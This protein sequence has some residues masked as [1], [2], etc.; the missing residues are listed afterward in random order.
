MRRLSIVAW[1]AATLLAA[2]GGGSQTI[3]GTA[4]PPPT[5]G[6]S[7]VTTV[8]VVSS[9]A[10]IAADGSNSATISATAKDANNNFVKGA[11][12]TFSAS[13]G[14]LAVTQA[15]TD[16]NGL[17]T[18]TLTAG[19]AAAGTS[20]TVTAASGTVSGKVSVMVANTQQTISVI[21]SLPQIPSDSSKAATI[22][23][24]VRNA[25]NQF[26]S[27]VPV[28]FT[29]TS[30][31]LTVTQAA[32]GVNGAA[33][34]TLN[35][36]GDPTDRT[37]TVTVT[38]G[39]STATVPVAVI[40]TK[41]TLTGSPN[42]V[43]GSQGT[44]TVALV[45]AGGNGIPNESVGLASA[46]GN[47]LSATTVTT[48]STGQKTFTMTAVNGGTD[49]ITATT[50]GLQATQS[51][52]VSSQ[53]FAFTAPA[54]NAQVN[55]GV[56]TTLTVAWTANGVAQSGQTVNFSATR[57]TLSASSA[58]TDAMGNASVTLT[59][60]TAGPSVISAS[61]NGVTAQ[62]TLNFVATLPT[63]VAVQA[64]P[65]TIATQ[66]QSTVTATVRDANNNLVQ[67]QVVDFAITKDSTGGSLSVA[68]ATTNAQGQAST[69]YT[70]STTTSASNGIIISATVQGTSVPP[71]STSLT[72]GGQTVFLSLGTGNLINPFS[73]TQYGL[74]Y[75]VQAVDAAGNGVNNVTVTFTV[76]SLGYIKGSRFWSGSTWATQANT[77]GT[78]PYAYVL[79]GI[80]GCRTE[81]LAGNGVLEP[82]E[83]YNGNGK[84]DPGLVVSTDVGSAITANGGS[85][86]V[87]L[88]YPR[89]HAYYVAVKLTATATVT[90]TQSSSSAVFW[91]Q[92]LAADF[93]SQNIAPPG[94]TSPYGTATTCANPN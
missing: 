15:T 55:L 47:T 13:A 2:C 85:A 62:M 92:G 26:V 67:G 36:A 68:S 9:A 93:N 22:T 57:G 31:G 45:D 25:Q 50:L 46:K 48:D 84:L 76:T 74:P 30:G 19:T 66:G 79:A 86:A 39:T 1:M 43:Q 56:V 51:V 89:D 82:G 12:V 70:A 88:I 24:L 83:D 34:A 3:T 71:G 37:I 78:D 59:S 21:T 42:L 52:V 33:T 65:S 16:A 73:T 23:A 64:S 28:T 53:N 27:G 6:G 7:T 35:A 87:N 10:Q 63:A 91:L 5:G 38:A 61:G 29:A 8:T 72:V 77:L 44:Y 49:T 14:G 40:G 41:L 75:T 94:P 81:D 20:I 58:T 69:V 18:A 4:P 11:T 80:D 54:A 17:A 32:T 90:G 60:A